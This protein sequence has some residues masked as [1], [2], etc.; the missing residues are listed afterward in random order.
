MVRVDDVYQKVLAL[1]N[2]EQRGYITPQDFNLFANQAQMEI[3]EQYF[4]D[5]NVA[6]KN[7]GNDTIYADID[8]MIE[9]KLQS[10]IAVATISGNTPFPF[11]DSYRI[12]DVA[13]GTIGSLVKCEIL[14]Y[15]DFLVAMT[16]SAPLLSP[17]PEMPIASIQGDQIFAFTSTINPVNQA[18]FV[19]YIRAP[20]RVNWTY[21]VINKQAMYDANGTTQHFE[22]HASEENQLVN[23]ILMLSGLANR[24]PDLMKAGQGMEMVATQKQPKI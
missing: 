11:A 18:S 15:Q 9:H 21:V 24:Q 4:Y 8:D 7:Q 6:R 5:I 1:A 3:F 17:T 16:Q 23:K 2:K 22:V 10:F 19:S 20:L 12:T 14:S 13:I